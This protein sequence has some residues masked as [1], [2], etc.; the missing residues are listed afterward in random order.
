MRTG[1]AGKA[2]LEGAAVLG[3]QQ[4]RRHQ[5]RD[6]LLVGDGLECRAHRDLGLS[7]ADVA[8]DQAVHRTRA[9][10]CRLSWRRWP[11]ADPAVGSYGKASSISRLPRRI[12]A[13]RKASGE[14]RVRRRVDEPVGDFRQRSETRDLVR[15]QSAPPILESR[16]DC[17][18]A[19]EY[20]VT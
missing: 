15:A 10:P 17:P 11:I 18:S 8:A 20:F 5:N 16:A 7:V 6:L 3:G 12:G 14:S 19:A 1:K 4:R 13:E 2:R 9:L